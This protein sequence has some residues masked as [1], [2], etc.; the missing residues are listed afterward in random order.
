MM[1]HTYHPM[2]HSMSDGDWGQCE[3]EI[4]EE[5]LA[6]VTKFTSEVS[7][8]IQSMA[9]GQELFQLDPEDHVRLNQQGQDMEKLHY[10]ERKFSLWL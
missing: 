4:K 1:T 6:F 2:F 10:F 8:S 9:P 7:D 5:F 3:L